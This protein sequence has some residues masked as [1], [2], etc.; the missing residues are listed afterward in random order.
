LKDGIAI[1]KA[2]MSFNLAKNNKHHYDDV[3]GTR[4]KF[5]LKALAVAAA[6][7]MS[8]MAFADGST[9]PHSISGN[10]GV[11][12]SYDLRGITNTPENEGATVQGGLDY[13]HESGFYLGYWGSSLGDAYSP[14]ALEH[15]FYLGYNGSFND[16]WG[17]QVGGVQYVYTNTD[18]SDGFEVV[19]GLS[20]KDFGITSQTLVKDVV[21]GNAGDTYLAA[22]YSYALPKD[23]S[24]N[25]TLGAYIYEDKGKYID[26][27]EASTF[28][29]RHFTVGLS[30]PI[31]DTGVTAS[32]D[33][34]AGGYDRMETKQKNK[35]VFGLGYSF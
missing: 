30:K 11:L 22:S 1:A 10:I 27:T 13:E 29:F 24:L 34:I 6:A 21:W 12:S 31:A 26:E 14:S 5:T 20:Y 32:M 7:T 33:F 17:F 23:F 16:D 9:S 25:T 2:K 3:R 8:T 15:D 35:V 4:M 18:D 28:S 19:L